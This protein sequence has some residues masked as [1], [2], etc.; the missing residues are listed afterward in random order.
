M[1]GR[2]LI[3]EI[4]RHIGETVTIAGWVSVRRD[5]GKL[6]FLDIRDRSGSVQA[7]VLPSAG[8]AYEAAQEIRSEHVVAIEG[9]VKERPGGA[10]KAGSALGGIEL[11]ISAIRTISAPAETLP[12]EVSVPELDLNLDTLLD[13]RTIALRN[14]RLQAIFRIY[15]MM[16]S[17]YAARMRAADFLEIK[18]PKLVGSATEGGANFFTVNYFDRKAYLAQSP[19]FYK[20]AGISIFERVF[21]VGSVFR[22]EP[23]FTTRHVNEYVGLDAELGFISDFS[24]VMDELEATIKY[25]FAEIGKERA[26]EL[27]LYGAAL[28]ADVPI[29]RLRLSEAVDILRE[30][31]GKEIEGGDIDAEGERMIGEYA[32]EKFGSDFVFLTHYP[33]ALRPFYT[34]PSADDPS[35]TESFDLIYHGLEI[36]SG[37]QRIHDYAQLSESIRSRGMNPDDFASYLDVFRYGCPPHGGWGLGSERI[38]QKLLGLGSIKEALLYPRDVK[39]LSP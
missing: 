12:F 28:P 27:A 14:A 25:V 37:G 8:P 34:M 3:A 39:R 18:T 22:A 17:A 11:E 16:L 19:Q 9:L 4:P 23:H 24:E 1:K 30:S 15:S 7:I 20:Q 21:E 35:V 33:T 38:V 2:L 13:H 29:P 26:S 36:A 5:H 10:E 6:I 32:K 31:Y